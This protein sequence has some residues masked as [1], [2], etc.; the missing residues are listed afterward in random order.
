MTVSTM[1]AEQAES[2]L[3]RL[4][5]PNDD[6]DE[7]W[8]ELAYNLSAPNRYDATLRKWVDDEPG[9]EFEGV[10]VSCVADVGGEGQGDIRYAVFCFTDGSGTKYF[11]KDG[12]YASY[13]GS[14]WD[15]EFSEVQP[16]ERVVTV[17]E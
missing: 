12:F 2:M 10:Y 3:R 7:Q 17:W 15:G 4:Y 11:R 1:T 8:D 5:H 14:T 9:Q 6:D 13:D 16:Q